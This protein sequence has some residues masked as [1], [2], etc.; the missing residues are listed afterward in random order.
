VKRLIFILAAF[1]LVG[2]GGYHIK[3]PTTHNT[4]TLKHV[5]APNIKVQELPQNPQ[6]KRIIDN[7]KE[8]AAFD[9]QG[10]NSL[11]QMRAAAKTNTTVL[12]E[13]L[14][15]Y[16]DTIKERNALVDMAKETE[17]RAN[18]IAEKWAENEGEVQ[19]TKDAAR[20]AGASGAILLLGILAL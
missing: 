1:A 20:F 8:Y 7:E 4:D 17:A 6:A 2:C 11:L 14:L 5:A 18:V 9:L 16:A 12:H 13:V 10:I 19:K 3:A 15:A